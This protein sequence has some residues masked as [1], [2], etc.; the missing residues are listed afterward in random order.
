[1]VVRMVGMMRVVGMTW[2]QLK[3][4]ETPWMGMRMW[5]GMRM[6][7]GMCSCGRPHM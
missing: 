3:A 4:M 6:R 5:V 1:M 2:V 7:L